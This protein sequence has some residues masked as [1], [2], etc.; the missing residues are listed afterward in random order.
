M[1]RILSYKGGTVLSAVAVFLV[2]II[3]STPASA[4]PMQYQ[5]TGGPVTGSF[6]VDFDTAAGFT[7]WDLNID[8]FQFLHP[9][10]Q[11][12]GFNGCNTGIPECTL[13][14]TVVLVGSDNPNLSFTAS[15]FVGALGGEYR[16]EYED[17]QGNPSDIKGTIAAVPEPSTLILSATGLLGLAG[18]RW[19][20][21]RR[22][23]QVG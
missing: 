8:G 7:D 3:S 12:G 5:I 21:R 9:E 1:V 23:A 16:G 11:P 15:P 13:V 18:Y 2:T 10:T 22:Q 20:Q 17:E 4:V 14:D 19:L 6:T